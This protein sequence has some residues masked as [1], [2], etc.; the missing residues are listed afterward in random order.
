MG[1]V[2]WLLVGL[3]V[4]FCLTCLRLHYLPGRFGDTVSIEFAPP[5]R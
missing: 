3:A 5:W 4:L 2:S 1:R